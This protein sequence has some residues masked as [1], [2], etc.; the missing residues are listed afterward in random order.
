M[1]FGRD[2]ID[3]AKGVVDNART[4]L[5]HGDIAGAQRRARIA[6][7]NAAHVQGRGRQVGLTAMASGRPGSSDSNFPS[8]IGA[9]G[10][11]DLAGGLAR[12]GAADR[13]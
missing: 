13:D 4:L 2:A 6:R 8:V 9:D 3:K 1:T 11:I 10:A 5:E 12:E 7:P